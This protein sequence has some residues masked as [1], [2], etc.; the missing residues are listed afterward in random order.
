MPIWYESLM[1][2]A[3]FLATAGTTHAE[4]AARIGVSQASVSRYA[5]GLRIPEPYPMARI[6]AETRGAVTANDFYEVDVPVSP[7]PGVEEE[8]PP[9]VH[10]PRLYFQIK[11]I[12]PEREAAMA[13]WR[14]ENAE[15]TKSFNDFIEKHGLFADQWRTW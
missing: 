9:F 12:T 7:P 13:R 3:A 15:A 2:L 10:E 14:E 5:A 4:F 6:V 1:K 11:P 8:G